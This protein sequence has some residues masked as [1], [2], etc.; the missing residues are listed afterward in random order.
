MNSVVKSAARVLDV[1]ELLS[2]QNAPMR[3]NDI[4]QVLELPKS[5]AHGLISTLLARGYVS[6]DSADRYAIVE[7][8][9]QGFGW[10]GGFEALLRSVAQPI[11]EQMRD[12]TG[13]TVFVCVRTHDQD[14]RLIC[15]AVSRQPVRYDAADQSRLPG[16]GTVM[17]RV[18]LAY[19]SPEIIDAYFARTELRPFNETTVTDEAAIRAELARIRHDGYGTIV[20]QYAVGGAGIAAPVRKMGGDVVAVFDIA[21]VTA[22]YEARRDEM[23]AAALRGAALISAR[24]GY[25]SPAG[26]DA[27]TA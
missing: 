24:L 10:V 2:S 21:T 14:A 13:E 8:F 7:E 25:R 3:L 12:E 17:G 5:S 18:L 6:K 9:R 1:L 16:Y 15:K 20:D 19:Q 26:D 4:A 11:V 22:R 27:P 23:L